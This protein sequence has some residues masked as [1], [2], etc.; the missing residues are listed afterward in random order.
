MSG[1][2]GWVRNDS[3]DGSRPAKN[4]DYTDALKDYGVRPATSVPRSQQAHSRMI[5]PP[6]VID[7]AASQI[8]LVTPDARHTLKSTAKNV[9]IVAH[10]FTGSMHEWPQEIFKRLPLLYVEAVKYLGSDDLEI[11]FV[12]HGDVR[13]DAHPLQVTRFGRGPELDTFLASFDRDCDGGGNG[14]ESQELIAYYLADRVDTSTANQVY[15]FFIT[16]E[17]GRDRIDPDDCQNHLG[18][19]VKTGLEKTSA[20]FRVLGRR[21]STYAILCATGSYD[22][23]PIESWWKKMLGNE[24]IVRLDDS[25]RVV[26]VM[27]GTIA[28]ATDQIDSFVDDLKSR[29]LGT[30]HGAVNVNAV[31]ASIAFV[32]NGIPAAPMIA[33]TPTRSL[34][35]P[36][37]PPAGFLPSHHTKKK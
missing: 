26:D 19:P 30:K 27:L 12:G 20:V 16:D 5:D 31:L 23:A 9:I 37:D 22:P 35:D 8:H 29:Q 28:K 25:R 1:A 10:D 7:V 3:D 32:G 33:K 11:L 13:T 36:P 18:V 6:R 24:H 21:M 4:D 15:M 17:P 14:G 2:F 34:L